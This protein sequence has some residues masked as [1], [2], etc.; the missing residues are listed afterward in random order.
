[1]K[2]NVVLGFLSCSCLAA[3]YCQPLA[4]QEFNLSAG[5]A[6]APRFHRVAHFQTQ[7]PQGPFV[8][9][10][11]DVVRA[12]HVTDASR[13]PNQA[14]IVRPAHMF[15]EGP[16]SEVVA[17][18]YGG[19]IPSQDGCSCAGAGFEFGDYPAD[20]GGGWLGGQRSGAA[21]SGDGCCTPRWFDVYVGSVHLS[22]DNEIRKP[23]GIASENPLGLIVL[24]SDDADQNSTEDGL[25]LT[26]QCVIGPGTNI[27]IDYFGLLEWADTRAVTDADTAQPDNL[28]S[29]FSEFGEL[30]AF[31]FPDTDQSNLQSITYLTKLNNAEINKRQRW[32]SP[33]CRWQGSHL[34]G[35]RYLRIE[36]DFVYITEA[37]EHGDPFDGDALRGPG[38][39]AYGI[40]TANDL[41]GP[42]VG[43]DLTLCLSPRV[44]VGAEAKAGIF[45][46][47]AEQK[48]HLQSHSG[49]ELYERVAKEDLAG[50]QE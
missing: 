15:Q 32:I 6:H 26:F 28:Y 27:E 33:N 30:G 1:M 8:A 38:R 5:P 48:S 40:E 45:L 23:V 50:V 34:C 19:W 7:R 41:V 35:I 39:F 46:L 31:G 18:S 43:G 9:G 49:S 20:F 36:E 25:Q 4:G 22:R 10:E 42:Q 12:D 11:N 44:R 47:R 37:A 3:W 13:P 2:L 24:E 14:P 21:S 29:V 16:A 17:T